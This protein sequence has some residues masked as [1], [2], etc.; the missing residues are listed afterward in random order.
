MLISDKIGNKELRNVKHLNVLKNVTSQRQ[1]NK[2]A[3][4][5]NV[6]LFAKNALTKSSNKEILLK[7]LKMKTKKGIIK[8]I[9][10][11]KSALKK[12]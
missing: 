12:S 2:K 7:I 10:L 6:V 5:M 3:V 1:S 8:P 9:V 4:S 11:I